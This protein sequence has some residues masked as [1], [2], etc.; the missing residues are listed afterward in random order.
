M[1]FSLSQTQRAPSRYRAHESRKLI[2]KRFVTRSPAV[3]AQRDEPHGGVMHPRTG[4]IYIAD[5]R[6]HR[7]LRIKQ[8]P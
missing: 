7:V 1:Y 6:N 4:D 8:Q 2:E 3:Q 5:S